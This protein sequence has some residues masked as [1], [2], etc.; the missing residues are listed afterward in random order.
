MAL[1]RARIEAGNT[2]QT[3]KTDDDGAGEDG[4]DDDL[5][6]LVRSCAV[7]ENAAIVI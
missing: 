2:T 7:F 6:V 4:H 1:L 5:P 3:P